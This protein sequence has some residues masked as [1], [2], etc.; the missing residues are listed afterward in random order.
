MCVD[1]FFSEWIILFMLTCIYVGNYARIFRIIYL[2]LFYVF[3]KTMLF[4]CKDI[5]L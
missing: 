3:P 2:F 5:V 1:L 4:L